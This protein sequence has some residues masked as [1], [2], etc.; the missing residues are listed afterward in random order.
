V[1]RA[2]RISENARSAVDSSYSS[3]VPA[4]VRA[5][6]DHFTG[7]LRGSAGR[8]D[9][10]PAALLSQARLAATLD[11]SL[12]MLLRR[13]VAVNSLL[14]LYLLQESEIFALS[15]DHRIAI[16]HTQATIFDQIIDAVSHEYTRELS[17]A[18]TFARRHLDVVKSLLA[19]DLIDPLELP[20]ELARHHLGLIVRGEAAGKAIV[21]L[22]KELDAS[23]LLVQPGDSTRWAWLGT[24]HLP[25]RAGVSAA[26]RRVMPAQT[27]I[28][29]GHCEVGISGWRATHLQAKAAFSICLRKGSISYYEDVALEAAAIQDHVLSAFLRNRYLDPICRGRSDDTTLLDTLKAYFAADRNGVSTSSALGVSRQTVTNRMRSVEERIGRTLGSCAA[30]LETALR[31][32]DLER[33]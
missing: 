31:L 4:T 14:T 20:Y 26:V 3:Q 6:Y 16:A 21:A 8:V 32:H 17:G 18:G 25:N 11:L 19:G 7:A 27:P 33:P 24:R 10:M 12:D 30:D 23:L 13:C 22:A 9:Q 2:N 28:A 1:S 29:V 15:S 5:A